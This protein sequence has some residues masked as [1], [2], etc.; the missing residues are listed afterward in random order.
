MRLCK[1]ARK[2]LR[3]SYPSARIQSGVVGLASRIFR[4][5]HI[6]DA[7]QSLQPCTEY[8]ACL[9]PVDSLVELAATASC[10]PRFHTP[11]CRL[12]Y[13]ATDFSQPP[14]CA[15]V[16]ALRLLAWQRSFGWATA[17][18]AKVGSAL[19][20]HEGRAGDSPRQAKTEVPRRP[21]TKTQ[22][23]S[24]ACRVCGRG[25]QERRAA[26]HVPRGPLVRGPCECRVEALVVQP[27]CS[28][29]LCWIFQSL[30]KGQKGESAV[31]SMFKKARMTAMED[32][33]TDARGLGFR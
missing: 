31:K 14:R 18:K 11:T 30:T 26:R 22:T 3:P 19:E 21:E 10:H 24:N 1:W 15:E 28:A 5:V 7:R 29:S 27:V 16:R 23:D 12:A 33:M 8:N 2:P 6:L 9:N 25:R 13:H 4:E 32:M 20:G 17:S